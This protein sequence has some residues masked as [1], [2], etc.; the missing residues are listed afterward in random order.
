MKLLITKAT[1][2]KTQLIF[3]QDSSSTTGAGLTG[4]TSASSGLT[5]YYYREEAGTGATAI[6]LVAAGALGTWES[7]GF[8]E[9]DST[10]MPGWYEV[11][12]PNA[13]LATAADF[14]GI[15]LKGATNMA[16]VNIEIQLTDLSMETAMRGTDSAALASTLNTKIPNNLNTTAS[17]NIGVD[18]ANVE[19]PT[20]AVDLSATDIQLVDT[21][22]TNTDMRGTDSAATATALATAQADLDILT[23]TDGA[24]LATAQ[25]NY[26][27]SVAGDAM[28][29]VTDAVDAAAIATDAIDADAIASDAGNLIADHTIRR[30]FA[31]AKASSNGDTKTG[32]SLLGAI[33]KLVNK[34]SIT[35]STAT[36]TEEDDSTALFTQTVTSDSGADPVTALD[37]D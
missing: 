30:T 11:G 2:S 20:T 19:N 34:F 31:N 27:P 8:F 15:Q 7:G 24:T 3:V 1:T 12:I 36:I 23:G 35:G 13:V 17:G 21:T 25:S 32:R 29:L 33:A 28:D 9:V 10:N 16:P 22:T 14:A 6:S 18:W 37:T 26:A 4:L 5:A